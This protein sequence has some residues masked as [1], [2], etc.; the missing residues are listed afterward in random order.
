[1]VLG[2]SA[3]IYLGF[4]LA[5]FFF[6]IQM[7]TLLD[8]TPRSVD[9]LT[10]IRAIYGGLNTGIGIMLVVGISRPS[11]RRFALWLIALTL[12]IAALGRV[13]GIFTTGYQESLTLLLLTAESAGA[14]T[15]LVTLFVTRKSP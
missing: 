13:V 7:T 15:A 10:D 14:L 8:S 3:F 11:V 2:A 9:L 4:G 12:G 1:M 6:P 5:F